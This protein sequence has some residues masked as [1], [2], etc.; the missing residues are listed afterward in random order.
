[1]S[2]LSNLFHPNSQTRDDL[3]VSAV[4]SGTLLPITEVPDIV[5]SE[6]VV[7]DGVAICPDSG[8]IVAPFD[9]VISRLIATSSAFAIKADCGLELYVTFGVGAIDLQGEGFVS[10][11]NV[12]Q[13]VKRGDEILNVDLKRIEDKI[14]STMTSMITVNS[15]AHITK[16]TAA[17]GKCTAGK[18]PALWVTL[19]K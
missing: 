14:K 12:G 11:V 8:V 19:A 17:S 18:T 13:R 10:C 16:V 1:M 6:K 9:G 2:F 7:G 15:S 3:E 5:I 4:V